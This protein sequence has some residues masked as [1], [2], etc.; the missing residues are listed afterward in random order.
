MTSKSM[1][2]RTTCVR[3]TMEIDHCWKSRR[4]IQGRCPNVQVQTI[5]TGEIGYFKRKVLSLDGL[6]IL[7]TYG[8]YTK[9][10]VPLVLRLCLAHTQGQS[11][12]HRVSECVNAALLHCGFES[13][14]AT[15]EELLLHMQ[16]I[17][18]E[19]DT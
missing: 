10:V 15:C 17:V 5:F 1:A 12:I 2:Y 6:N 16:S 11:A 19:F 13:T 9:T 18:Y 3:A 4:A 14:F 7:W 8:T